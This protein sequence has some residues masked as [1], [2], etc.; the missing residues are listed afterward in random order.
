MENRCDRGCGT[1][2]INF[3]MGCI[4]I[5]KKIY[6]KTRNEQIN[7]NMGCIEMKNKY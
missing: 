4:E 7:F 5:W 1:A 6:R 3:N 2:Q